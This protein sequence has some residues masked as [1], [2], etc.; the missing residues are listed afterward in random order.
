MIVRSPRKLTPAPLVLPALLLMAAGCST[1]E[2]S[3]KRDDVAVSAT[4][5]ASAR[6][7]G[8]KLDV[9]PVM[10]G[11]VVLV[12][13]HPVELAVYADGRVDGL[14]YDER[15]QEVAADRVTELR[16]ILNV[17]GAAKPRLDLAWDATAKRFRARAAATGE[18]VA[19]PI[20]V[21]LAL[22]GK[23]LTGLLE[24]YTILP[25][26]DAQLQ[27][28]A[29]AALAAPKL[30]AKTKLAAKPVADAKA[31]ADAKVKSSKPKA[32]SASAD[33]RAKADAKLT[34]P[35][36]KVSASAK[37]S[38]STEKKKA[39]AGARLEAGASFGL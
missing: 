16:V 34:V 3:R 24:T 15:G 32:P 17:V 25:A 21:T 7:E 9:A 10:G 2:S 19:Q 28:N 37:A 18:L 30:D 33:V 31:L 39:G 35:K 1:E 38:T 13:G 20:D 11:S 12:G 6:A 4:A 5:S 14:V 26:L 22:D 29:G 36:P 23:S 8:A 27:A